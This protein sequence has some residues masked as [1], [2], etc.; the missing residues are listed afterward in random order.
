MR[1][2]MLATA[3]AMSFAFAIGSV[4]AADQFK[5]LKGVKAVQMTKGEL[6]S[7]KGMDHHFFVTPPG[8]GEAV[9]HDTDQQQDPTAGNFVEILRADGT[10]RLAAPSY[11]GLIL[12]AC[13]N[14][15]ISGPSVAWCV[16]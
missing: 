1:I 7:V 2:A 5:T 10:I 6:S 3:S 11:N 14:G 9:R 13:G 12:H 16:P 8:T 15:V 4:S